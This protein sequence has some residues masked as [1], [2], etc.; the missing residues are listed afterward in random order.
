MDSLQYLVV[1]IIFCAVGASVV[2]L[3]KTL[4]QDRQFISLIGL[5]CMAMA[6]FLLLLDLMLITFTQGPQYILT[7]LQFNRLVADTGFAGRWVFTVY[8]FIGTGLGISI[9]LLARNTIK[10]FNKSPKG[11]K[12]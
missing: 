12:R 10:K 2:Y 3:M 9:Y 7:Y 11:L 6:F 8:V 4:R 5:F 1:L